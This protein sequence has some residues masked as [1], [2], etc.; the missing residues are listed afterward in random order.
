MYDTGHKYRRGINMSSVEQN[1]TSE[2]RRGR[3]RE[4]DPEEA[5]SRATLEFW[6]RG[7]SGTS[8]EAL[9]AATRMSKP[10][11]YGAIGDKRDWYLAAVD[12]YVERSL[13]ALRDALSP[14]RTLE[15]GLLRVYER[16]LAL[17]FANTAGPLGCFLVG[18]AATEAAHDVE[19]RQRLGGALR[20][21]TDEIEKRFALAIERREIPRGA[22][23]ELL[24]EM[25]AAV[26]FSIALRARAGDARLA[27]RK[28]AR[29]SA[30][31]LSQ[32]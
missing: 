11:L 20:A 17:Y 7:Y 30:A 32:P 19:V 8:F 18:T 22:D 4:Y 13:A 27:L 21:F 26:L 29:R 16:S 25:A 24:A 10:S 15:E 12:R 5:L 9:S 23:A 28:F 14:E 3:P 6:E 31:R 1:K 2:R